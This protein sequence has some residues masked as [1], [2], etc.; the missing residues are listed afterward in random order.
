[1]EYNDHGE[2]NADYTNS[3][4]ITKHMNVNLIMSN[5]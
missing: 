3:S 1:M 5:A 4:S 2:E